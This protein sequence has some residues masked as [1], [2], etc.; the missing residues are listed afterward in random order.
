MKYDHTAETNRFKM[1]AFE[2]TRQCYEIFTCHNY[3]NLNNN[4]VKEE[5]LLSRFLR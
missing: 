1:H 2:D 4:A 3:F 5:L